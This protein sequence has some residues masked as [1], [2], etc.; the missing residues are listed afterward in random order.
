MAQDN[1]DSKY[2]SDVCDFYTIQRLNEQFKAAL[3]E[4][5]LKTSSE[6]Y[7]SRKVFLLYNDGSYSKLF[8]IIEKITNEATKNDVYFVLW[9]NELYL[10]FSCRDRILFYNTQRQK[11]LDMF[12]EKVE[13]FKKLIE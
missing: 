5:D 9:F 6:L 8:R 2:D 1:M 12:E 11:T 3:Y 7:E 13:T 10:Q 4:M